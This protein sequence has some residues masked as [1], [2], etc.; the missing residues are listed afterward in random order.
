MT[1]P[2]LLVSDSE[3]AVRPA[4]REDPGPTDERRTPR[5]RRWTLSH[6]W[7]YAQAAAVIALCLFASVVPSPLYSAY[8]QRWHFSPSTLT[9][10]FATYAFGV[11]AAL[12]LAGRL[13]DQAGRRPALLA[14]MAT[15]MVSLVLYIAADSTL[16]LFVA[17]AVQG[18]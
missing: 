17:R 11:L 1:E 13:S 8:A 2:S 18:I 15:L 4:D 3:H 7:G 10:I 12:L 9:L 5:P 6:R 16:W 14:D